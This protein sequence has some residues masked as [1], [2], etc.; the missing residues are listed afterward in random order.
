[1]T[2]FIKRLENYNKGLIQLLFKLF[3]RNE[4]INPP[5][6]SLNIHKILLLRTDRI[7]DMAVSIPLIRLLKKSIP[8][9]SIYVF[10]S[11]LNAP[12]IADD[13]DITGVFI[14]RKNIFS[15]LNQLLKIRMKGIDLSLNLNLNKSLTNAILSHIAVPNGIK[16]ASTYNDEY[17]NFYNYLIDIKRNNTTPM[18]L[19]L[20]KYL[21]L[22][23][24]EG[25]EVTNN[26]SIYL[27]SSANETASEILEELELRHKEF[28]AFNI[29]SSHK[30]RNTTDDFVIELLKGL[31]ERTPEPILLIS[32]PSQR[33]RLI[34]ISK[35][36][37]N[38]RIKLSPTM[39]LQTLT[40]VISKSEL[41]ITPDTAIVHIACGINVPVAA[42]YT[43]GE[44]YYNEW[45]PLVA[46]N[47]SIFAKGMAPV[48]DIDPLYALERIM[49]FYDE[50]GFN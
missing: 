46:K 25:I 32:D 22:F 7:G 4:L 21:E 31:F 38:G 41:V 23:D 12:L 48:S 6:D 14:R 13:P 10:A 26:L 27:S 40:A 39:D 42:F 36:I 37:N 16:V 43:R 50:I 18:A 47:V 28:I 44:R 34:N 33:N 24:I 15:I 3:V 45:Q 2:N 49:K 8:N 9:L 30:N 5:I 35:R 17:S 19:L 20:L 11:R 1:M 29:S